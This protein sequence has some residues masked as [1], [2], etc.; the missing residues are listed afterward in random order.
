MKCER[1]WYAKNREKNQKYSLFYKSR[2]EWFYI[3]NFTKIKIYDDF[4]IT[5]VETRVLYKKVEKEFKYNYDLQRKH[6]FF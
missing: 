5:K 3:Q 4:N 1:Q 6:V 2:N